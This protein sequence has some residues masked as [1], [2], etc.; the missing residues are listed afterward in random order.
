MRGTLGGVAVATD[1]MIGWNVSREIAVVPINAEKIF[2]PFL[3]FYI[4]GKNSQDWLTGKQKEQHMS[5][6]TLKI[7]TRNCQ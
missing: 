2:P 3:A 5:E 7:F 6:L 1:E 4:A